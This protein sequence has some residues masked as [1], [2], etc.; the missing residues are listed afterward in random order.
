MDLVIAG[1]LCQG[2]LRARTSHSLDDSRSSLLWISSSSCNV[3][4]PTNLPLYGL[5][6]RNIPLLVDFQMGKH[7]VCQ[8]L[9]EPIFVDAVGLD[10]YSHRP[11]WIWTNLT[12][13]STLAVV[14]SAMPLSFDQRVDDILN[15]NHIFLPVV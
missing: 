8:Y 12:S 2:H 7:Y 9:G 6:S 14:F 4:L 15:P 11:Q 3:G 13:L 10:S 5:Y 1:W